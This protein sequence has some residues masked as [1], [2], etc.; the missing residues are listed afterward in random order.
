MSDS[1][2]DDDDVPEGFTRTRD[3]RLVEVQVVTLG[4]F[5][6]GRIYAYYAFVVLKLILRQK[7][8]RVLN[9]HTTWTVLF[10]AVEGFSVFLLVTF[11]P[12]SIPDTIILI[13]M[14]AFHTI[15]SVATGKRQPLASLLFFSSALSHMPPISPHCYSQRL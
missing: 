6:R 7:Y 5:I 8:V 3:G 4:S 12:D 9:W 11:K 10:G 1:D 14:L 13:I 2:D 15:F